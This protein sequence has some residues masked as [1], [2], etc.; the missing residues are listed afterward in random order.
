MNRTIPRPLLAAIVLPLVVIVGFQSAWAAFACRVDGK[1]RDHCC[2]KADKQDREKPVDDAPRMAA[3]SCC[4]VTIYESAEAP[5]AREVERAVFAHLPA[6][7]PTVAFTIE[8]PRVERV[9][10]IALMARPPPSR[11]PLFLDKQALLR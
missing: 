2:C 1:V 4:D 11:V 9:A 10:T 3:Q 8:A 5:V 6:V 7:I